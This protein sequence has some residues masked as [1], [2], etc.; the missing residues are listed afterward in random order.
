MLK[1]FYKLILKIQPSLLC[2]TNSNFQVNINFYLYP[3]NYNPSKG[4]YGELKYFIKPFTRLE[5]SSIFLNS[6]QKIQFF[7]LRSVERSFRSIKCSF[8]SIEQKLNSDRTFQKLQDHFLTI[9]IDLIKVSTDR[10]C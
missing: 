7:E 1:G 5:T 2:S 8:R 10:K 4:T 6:H 3:Y 9:S